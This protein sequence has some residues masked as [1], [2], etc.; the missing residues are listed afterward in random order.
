MKFEL[1]VHHYFHPASVEMTV[2]EQQLANLSTFQ[3]T[4]MTAISD[5]A[6]AQTAHNERMSTAL[7]NLSEDIASLNAKIVELQ[8]TSGAITQED[9]MLLDE[10]QT[11]AEALA[12]RIEAADALTPPAMP[13]A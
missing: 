4:I 2:I 6:K 11:Q 1:N 7:T 9:Q 10:L 5:F 13:V 12:A 8:S 3:G